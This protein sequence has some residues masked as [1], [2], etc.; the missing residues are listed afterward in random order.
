MGKKIVI[1]GNG[2]DL[3][4]Y[5]PTSYN[6]LISILCEVEL[7]SDTKG[8]VS[9]S[10][11]FDGI[12][13]QKNQWFYN[14]I[15]EYYDTDNINFDK[16][17][18]DS[19][20]NRLE[21][22]SWFQYFKT[23][24][25]N[26]IETWIDFETEIER[27][28]ISILNYFDSFNN[29]E[30][31]KKPI[32][33]YNFKTDKRGFFVPYSDYSAYFKSKLQILIL[34]YFN[35]FTA[36][37]DVWKVNTSFFLEIDEEIQYYKEKDFFNFLYSSLEEFIGIF[38]DYIVYIIDPFYNNLYESKKENFISKGDDFLFKNVDFIFSFNYTST[39]N[40]FYKNGIITD[41]SIVSLLHQS[42]MKAKLDLIHG[43]AVENWK[44]NI[45][46]LKMVLGVND[47]HDSLKRHKLF[48]FTKYFQKLH[49]QTDYLFLQPHEENII[50]NEKVIFYFWGH[51][52]DYSDRQYIREV[53]HFVN[54]SDSIIKIFYHS[55]SAKGDQ[56]KNLLS[57]IE[58]D[59]IESLMKNKI[60]QFIESTPENLFNEL[61]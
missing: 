11:L 40:L 48:Q 17:A 46:N 47:I 37:R 6:H 44:Q 53:F 20:Q 24:D 59:V 3:R 49:K 34:K 45:D 54:A 14:R 28:L 52:L 30:F 61:C 56:L 15:K 2:F 60:L 21:K 58:K 36:E 18:I 38:N 27:I 57:I 7:L 16:D 43:I 41:S 29:N 13:K 33:S 39:Y 4:H 26:K 1:I 35:L 12:F 32:Y 10:D 31:Q 50:M 23:V 25:E 9:F 42:R 22:N 8:F 51:S 5:L 55:I 19:I